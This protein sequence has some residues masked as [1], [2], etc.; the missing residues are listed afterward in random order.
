MICGLVTSWSLGLLCLWPIAILATTHIHS[1]YVAAFVQLRQMELSISEAM[2]SNFDE[3]VTGLAHV[4]LSR[5]E[6][7][8]LARTDTIIQD[9]QRVTYHCQVL[10]LWLKTAINLLLAF[11][12]ALFMLICMNTNISPS[13]IASGIPTMILAAPSLQVAIASLGTAKYFM[14]AVHQIERFIKYTPQDE[15]RM[16]LPTN[17]EWSLHPTIR[18]ADVSIGYG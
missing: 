18:F 15:P 6:A 2:Y 1:L 11:I 8:R 17:H 5:S 14:K 7:K 16:I 10:E 4:A 9:S 12:M 13:A 3:N